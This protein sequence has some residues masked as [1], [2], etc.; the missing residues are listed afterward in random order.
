MGVQWWCKSS[1]YI[2]I[3]IHPANADRS[4]GVVR[5][6]EWGGGEERKRRG[7]ERARRRARRQ[8]GKMRRERGRRGN[9][10]GRR[11]R[12]ESRTKQRKTGGEKEEETRRRK[13]EDEAEEETNAWGIMPS[14]LA[15]ICFAL[16]CSSLLWFDVLNYAML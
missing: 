14:S 7:E 10:N 1:I 5:G 9:G 6:K 3:L 13:K 16:P 2:Y 11:G 8:E 15:L 12:E 4:E